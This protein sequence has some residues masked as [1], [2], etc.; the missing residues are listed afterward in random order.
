ML[1]G[2]SGSGKSSYARESKA[3][4]HSSDAIRN[5]LYGDE[6]VQQDHERVFNLLHS[7]VR[8]DLLE[9]RDVIYDATNLNRK[10]RIAFLNSIKNIPCFKE[11][12]IFVQPIEELIKNDEQ[13][14]RTVGKDVIMKQLKQFQ[15]PYYDEGWEYIDI[16]RDTSRSEYID[17]VFEQA[18]SFNQWNPHHHLTVY[19]HCSEVHTKICEYTRTLKLGL[20]H[21][22]GKLFT[23]TFS[24][25]G[26]AH[27][28]GH[29][30]VSA[31][32]SYL[33]QDS[34]LYHHKDDYIQRAYIISLHM[35]HYSYTDQD[36][37]E[38]WFHTLPFII[39]KDLYILTC[40]DN[41]DKE[42]LKL[43]TPKLAIP[44]FDFN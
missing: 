20:L 31:Y 34:S 18:K 5:E 29:E 33:Y 9:G 3:I 14:E 26:I 4:V 22:L 24:A 16:Y 23:Q 7:R 36:S 10:R 27:Y 11:C 38:K 43:V 37:Y 44:I 32:L 12:I 17:Q 41:E 2:P 8:K 35:R 39:Q 25:D 1:V 21:D 40:A 28:Y 30:N 6:S 19:W 15:P 42:W 13:R